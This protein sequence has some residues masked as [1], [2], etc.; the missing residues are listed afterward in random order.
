MRPL[1]LT[2]AGLAEMDR[3]LAKAI[4]DRQQDAGRALYALGAQ[5]R[6]DSI[7]QT[8]LDWGELRNSTYET[9]P[10]FEGEGVVVEVGVGGAAAD[11]AIVQHERLDFHHEVGNAKFLENAM[12]AMAPRLLAEMARLMLASDDSQ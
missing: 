7:R 4:A 5:V 3:R 11:Y 10:V 12:N 6:D 9:L 1:Q 8:P 2:P